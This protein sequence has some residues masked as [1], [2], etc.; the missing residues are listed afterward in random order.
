ME[1]K[2]LPLDQLKPFAKNPNKHPDKQINSLKK[3]MREFGF[4]SPILLSQD[5]MVIAGHA[6]LQAATELGLAEV[7]TIFIDLPYEKAVAYVIADNQLARL[8]EVD[9]ELMRDLLEGVLQIPDFDIEAIGFDLDEVNGLLDVEPLE[10]KEDIF[11]PDEKVETRCKEGDL[12]QLGPHRLLC[13][14][15]TKKEDVNKLMDGC[16]FH[17][18]ATSPPY[19]Q[20]NS[21][22]DLLTNRKKEVKLYD[23]K[24]SD[25][26]S[27]EDYY[28]FL[29][30]VL[31]TSLLY[32]NQGEHTI[33]W[34]VSYNANRRD[35]YGKIIFSDENPYR[36]KETII[37]DK[38]HSL[39]IPN[40]GI[41]SR[42]CE[43]LFVMSS[44]ETYRTSQIYKECRWNYWEIS[45]NNSQLTGEEV[46][47]RAAF[48]I[49]F[50]SQIIT[51]FS[52]ETDNIYDPFC[53]SGTSIIAGEQLNR[54]CFAME[55]EPNYC[56]V[57]LTRW[58][59]F[60]GKTAVKIS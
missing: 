21:Y 12:W 16:K 36:V 39:N 6:R 48:P 42:R 7:P 27:K 19:N 52:F 10:V 37:W 4:T 54:N 29:I 35:D 50:I 59:Q 51:D 43:F 38:R 60:T 11:N 13:G 28:N 15:S 2:L 31:K 8:A 24:H 9:T 20:G 33:A 46:E 22:G 44:N 34:N 25:N 17:L 57:I 23:K 40:V 58:E 30:T 32:V 53:G 26:L 47:H 41:Y 49:G 5:N 55:L 1:I 56:D 3:S 18:L 45:N 14:D